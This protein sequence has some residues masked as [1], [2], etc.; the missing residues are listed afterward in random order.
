MNMI[1]LYI[2]WAGIIV[3]FAFAAQGPRVDF[4]KCTFV[5][6]LVTAGLM[7]TVEVIKRGKTKGPEEK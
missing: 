5:A 3:I 7:L 2:M 1:Q 4:W 6:A